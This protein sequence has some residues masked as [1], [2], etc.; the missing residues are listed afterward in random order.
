MPESMKQKPGRKAPRTLQG[1]TIPIR[2]RNFATRSPQHQHAISTCAHTIRHSSRSA[3]WRFWVKFSLRSLNSIS[4]KREHVIFVFGW[5]TQ[6][7][8]YNADGACSLEM[9]VVRGLRRVLTRGCTHMVSG[10]MLSGGIPKL[11]AH[12]TCAT[13]REEEKRLLQLWVGYSYTWYG[14]YGA[15]SLTMPAVRSLR[16]VLTRGCTHLM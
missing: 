5:D 2:R 10:L 14:A 8:W 4:R 12:G 6:Y 16:R 11:V 15:C 3:T 9:P 7:T 1:S 13:T